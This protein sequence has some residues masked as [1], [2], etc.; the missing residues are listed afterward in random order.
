MANTNQIII[1]TLTCLSPQQQRHF[2]PPCPL[3]PTPRKPHTDR[4]L[5]PWKKTNSAFQKYKDRKDKRVRPLP[6]SSC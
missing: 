1:P 2:F 3:S 5:L 6:P 4:H